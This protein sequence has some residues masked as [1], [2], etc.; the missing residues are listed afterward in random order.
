M[1]EV[2]EPK[3]TSGYEYCG[4]AMALHYTYIHMVL[5]LY[6]L[7]F[8][9]VYVTPLHVHPYLPFQLKKISDHE[10]N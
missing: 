6:T 5:C 4:S 8:M 9:H 10:G 1:V 7:S 2:D 3:R